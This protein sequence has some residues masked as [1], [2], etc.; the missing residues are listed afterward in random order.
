MEGSRSPYRPVRS[1]LPPLMCGIPLAKF[2]GLLE[3]RSEASSFVMLRVNPS[4]EFRLGEVVPL[5]SSC[6]SLFG[7]GGLKADTGGGGGTDALVE[8]VEGLVR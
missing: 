7:E 2:S 4:S 5:G 1:S 8:V 6:L 3:A